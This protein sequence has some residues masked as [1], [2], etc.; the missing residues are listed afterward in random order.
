VLAETDGTVFFK[1]VFTSPEIFRY[2]TSVRKISQK[3]SYFY[4]EDI[5]GNQSHV[6]LGL[7]YLKKQNS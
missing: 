4:V 7:P 5:H 3:C 1:D 2:F 6:T